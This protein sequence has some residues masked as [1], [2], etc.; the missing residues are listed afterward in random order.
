MSSETLSRDEEKG[1][2]GKREDTRA[3]LEA[4]PDELADVKADP[5]LV[6]L[7]ASDDPQQAPVLKRWITVLVISSAS[8]CVT[9]SSSIVSLSHTSLACSQTDHSQAAFTEAGLSQDFGVSKEVT[10][11]AISLFV[12]GL[13]LG[14]LVVGPLSEVYGRNIVYKLSYAAFFVFS[15]PIA[16]APDIGAPCSPVHSISRS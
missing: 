12:M 5:F 6:T 3:G 2:A 11:L 13:G 7:D 14:P 1:D 9:C 8:L 10:I 15:F 16:F 4:V